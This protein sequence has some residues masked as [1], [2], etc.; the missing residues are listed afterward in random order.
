MDTQRTSL[1]LQDDWYA[2]VDLVTQS[3]DSPH[4]KRAYSRALVDFLTWFDENGRPN[5]TKATINAYREEMLNAGKSRSSI[6]QALSAIRKLA[7]EAADNGLVPPTLAYGVERVKGVKQ[8]GVRAGNWLTKEE[9]EK[10]V[11]TPI[12][13]WQ[14]EDI[15]LLKALRDQAILV[16]MVGTGLRRS[17]VAGLKWDQ[18][19]QRD[20]R[21][22]I[23]DLVGKRGRVRSVGIPP[24]VKV[25]LDKWGEA[26]GVV[27]G[28]IFRA[29]NKDGQL[30][31]EVKTKGGYRADGNLTPQAIY[32][33]VKEHVLAM[34]YVNRKGEP[35]L[36]AHDLRRTAAALALK[37]GADLRQIQQML[38]HASMTTT[39]RYLEPMRSLQITA[40]DFIQIEL[41]MA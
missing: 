5:F 39:E 27:N 38:G 37:G 3:V 9:A 10:L 34:G 17:E 7:N 29:L 35:A 8:E 4:S 28:R 16:V 33:V 31:G 11:N 25:A 15:P 26:S 24:W 23:I 30:A 20:G 1:V 13:R 12:H 2:I 22:A 41:A 32:N 14:R 36:A 40:G 21:W 19:Q 6:N 18:V